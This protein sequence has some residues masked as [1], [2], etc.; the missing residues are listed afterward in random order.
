MQ[1]QFDDEARIV[2]LLANGVVVIDSAAHLDGEIDVAVHLSL[3]Q[4]VL[5]PDDLE[6]RA[7]AH[8]AE[9]LDEVVGVVVLDRS[10]DEIDHARRVALVR[11]IELSLARSSPFTGLP[12]RNRGVP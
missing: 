6:Q 3:G 4:A 10:A 1:L 9:T 7:V 8:E 5:D 11:R 12:G 2:L